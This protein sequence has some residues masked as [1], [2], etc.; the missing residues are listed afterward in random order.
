MYKDF[1]ETAK[2]IANDK[3]NQ[4]ALLANMSAHIYQSIPQFNWVG[5]YLFDEKGLVLGPFQGKTA[6]TYIPL[7]RGVCG[8]AARLKQIVVVPDVHVH[9]D[10]IACDE[11]SQ[12][13]LVIPIVIQDKLYAV[14]DIDS[15]V[16]NRFDDAL[17]AAIEEIASILRISIDNTP[18]FK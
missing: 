18:F 8:Q 7:D 6:T 3:P 15:P 17:I 5:F 16:I 4:L 11:A 14:L 9:P 13:E 12:S 1:I 10:H 2:L